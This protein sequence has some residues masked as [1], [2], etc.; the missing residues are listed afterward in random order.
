[1][2]KTFPLHG[3]SP[4]SSRL[5]RC[6][7]MLCYNSVQRKTIQSHKSDKTRLNLHPV[8]LQLDTDYELRI[9]FSNLTFSELEDIDLT[10]RVLPFHKWGI[11][12][13]QLVNIARGYKRLTKTTCSS[14]YG[15]SPE[16]LID[17]TIIQPFWSYHYRL[18]PSPYSRQRRNNIGE[19]MQP[20][21][22][23]HGMSIE[24]LRAEPAGA[25][26]NRLLGRLSS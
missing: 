18:K 20:W 22:T 17:A 11:F 6:R 26:V 23:P 7:R 2:Q 24:P 12:S 21:W 8:V 10:N 3:R 25:A 4:R 19:K 9:I 15:C 5:R 16:R 14:G 13:Y 1:M